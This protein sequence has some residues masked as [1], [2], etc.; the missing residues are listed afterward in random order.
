MPAPTFVPPTSVHLSPSRKSRRP[1]LVLA[2]AALATIATIT[3]LCLR[4]TSTTSSA[5]LAFTSALSASSR[6]VS[7][8]HSSRPALDL[9]RTPTSRDDLLAAI[10]EKLG[11]SATPDE[12]MGVL[13]ALAKTDAGLAIDLAHE[14][15]RTEEEKTA[16]VSDLAKEWAGRSPQQAW[17]WLSHQ[18][19]LRLR[20]LAVGTVPSVMIETMAR[21]DPALLLRNVDQLVHAGEGPL[22]VAPVVAVHLGLEALTANHQLDAARQA[23]ET[24]ARDPAHPAIGEAAYVTVANALAASSRPDEAAKWILSMPPSTERDIA[25]VEYPAH[26][27]DTD[28][29]AALVWAEQSSPADL[30]ARTVQRTFND[31]AERAP[32]EA[33][34]WLGSYL[35]RTPTG[36][37]T[38]KLIGA[39]INLGPAVKTNPTI[40]LQWAG[41]ISD[42]A[43]RATNEERIV[44]RW[45]RQD[46][47]AATTYLANSALITPQRKQAVLQ[48][49]QSPGFRQSEG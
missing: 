43:I 34:E 38:D 7:A 39:V 4:P 11:P 24:W 40:A 22:G 12:I 44:L 19:P 31:W 15:G 6:P 18:D 20:D 33:G 41:L 49:M 26:W 21:Q 35:T 13:N 32:A 9:S 17:A 8:A 25:L 42:P 14:L 48:K 46:E 29:R 28:P 10:R 1:A 47:S 2:C 45:A 36:V 16:W 30:R 3:V 23:V 5:K 27:A 37:D